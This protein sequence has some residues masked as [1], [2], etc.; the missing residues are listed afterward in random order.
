[1]N[2]SPD[3]DT[4]SGFWVQTEHSFF[5]LSRPGM[6][7]DLPGTPFTCKGRWHQILQDD[8]PQRRSGCV[9]GIVRGQDKETYRKQD[10]SRPGL[11]QTG[12]SRLGN[13][14]ASASLFGNNVILKSG[15]DLPCCA[16]SKKSY[17]MCYG[18]QKWLF[19]KGSQDCA[20]TV[21]RL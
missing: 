5:S 17:M 2:A 4:V 19:A 20:I 18:R 14:A 10:S 3:S 6:V 12:R 21:I 16:R 1:M 9:Q 11:R 15:R 13:D 7:F 8:L